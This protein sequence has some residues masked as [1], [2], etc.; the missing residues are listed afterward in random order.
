MPTWFM[1]E[2]NKHHRVAEELWLNYPNTVGGV[3]DPPKRDIGANR[4]KD[5]GP[6]VVIP[7]PRAVGGSIE[8]RYETRGR[9]TLFAYIGP[10]RG[11]WQRIEWKPN[12]PL[13]TDWKSRQEGP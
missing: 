6:V 8:I 3:L 13:N 11:A 10:H 5:V 4:A 1:L 12:L 7:D 2:G 9:L